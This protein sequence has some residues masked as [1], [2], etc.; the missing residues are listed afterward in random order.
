MKNRKLPYTEEELEII[1]KLYATTPAKVIATWMPHSSISISKKAHTMGLRKTKEYLSVQGRKIALKQWQNE[2]TCSI[3]RKTC[4]IKGYTPWNKGQKLSKEHIAKLTGTYKKGNLPH[5]NL[6]IGSTRNIDGYNEIKYAN[7][8]WMSL[9]RYNWQQ[10]HGEIPKNMCVF[11]L[12]GDRLNDNISNL[13]LVT[14]KDLA[15]LNRNHNKLP[16]ELKEV[17]ILVNQI[18]QK[19]K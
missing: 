2:K 19:T 7:H 16:Q 11:K 5:N 4:F 8:K 14:R 12:D 6:P 15:Q 3:A 17:Q 13:C 9:A 10:V 18:K 1:T